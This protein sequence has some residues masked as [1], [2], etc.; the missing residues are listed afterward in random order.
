MI[1]TSNQLGSVVA[2]QRE[3]VGAWTYGMIVK[4]NSADHNGESYKV[5]V[6]KI[7][8]LITCNTR[9]IWNMQVMAEQHT[10]SWL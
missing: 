9:H 7:G 6:M 3:D 10:E 5:R 2:G 8:K 1:K 4:G